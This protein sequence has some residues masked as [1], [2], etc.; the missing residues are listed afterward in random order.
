MIGAILSI[1]SLGGWR[2]FA[3]GPAASRANRKWR[4]GWGGG[5]PAPDL[6]Q[7]QISAVIIAANARLQRGG[8]Y[9]LRFQVD[10]R[11]GQGL[12]P[13]ISLATGG[14]TMRLMPLAVVLEVASSDAPILGLLV[15][16]LA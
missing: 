13:L 5:A 2:S 3:N 15:D 14:K 6:C 16:S 1:H 10:P 4:K 8:H 7:Q 11:N 12:V 9:D